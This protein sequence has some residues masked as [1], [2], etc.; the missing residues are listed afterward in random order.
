MIKNTL[1]IIAQCFESEHIT[2]GLGG[3]GVLVAYDI[4]ETM[5]DIDIVVALEDIEKAKKIMDILGVLKESGKNCLVEREYGYVYDMNGVKVEI[6]SNM[7]LKHSQGLYSVPFNK[8]RVTYRMSI[9]DLMIP[10]MALEDWY[11]IYQLIGRQD[12]IDQIEAYFLE[13]GITHGSYLINAIK[14]N[15]PRQLKVDIV[16]MMQKMMMD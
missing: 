7:H 13:N 4:L 16:K 11:V 10:V 15:I 14:A 5:H 1:K 3:S 6:M 8:N 12:R 2:Y 9:D